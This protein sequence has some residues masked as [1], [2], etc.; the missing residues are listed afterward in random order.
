M[1]QVGR[2]LDIDKQP[3]RNVHFVAGARQHHR[4]LGAERLT[5]LFLRH[6]GG[7]ASCEGDLASANFARHHL[8]RV[9]QEAL[10][11]KGKECL[12]AGKSDHKERDH[13]N[14]ELDRRRATSIPKQTPQRTAI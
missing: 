14:R 9:G 12:E 5:E 2:A 1:S 7:L 13:Q 8:R 4:D 10:A 6:V 11:R 3:A